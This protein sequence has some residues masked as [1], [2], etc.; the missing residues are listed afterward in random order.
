MQSFIKSFMFTDAGRAI[1][2]DFPMRIDFNSIVQNTDFSELQYLANY[3]ERK[4]CVH[5]VH[6]KREEE[7]NLFA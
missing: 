6:S 4:K 1:T 3:D 2:K 5:I 7:R